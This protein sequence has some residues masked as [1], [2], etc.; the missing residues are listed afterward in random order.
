[1]NIVSQRFLLCFQRLRDEGRVRSAR[2]FAQALDYLPQSWSEVINGRREVTIEIIRRA[3]EVFQFNPTYIFT[4]EGDFFLDSI[5]AGFRLTTVLSAETGQEK[6]VH[7]PLA[8]QAGYPVG[9]A[10]VNYIQN[11]PTFSLPDH[12]Y[13][14]GAHRCF[15][16]AGDAM[17]PILFEGDKVIGS[18]VKPDFWPSSLKS[19]HVY[20]LVTISE[21]LVRRL[22]NHLIDKG[23]LYLISDNPYYKPHIIPG[24]EVLEIWQVRSKI[25]P[26]LNTPPEHMDSL[27]DQVRMLQET[28]KAQSKIVSHLSEK[29]EA[30]GKA[31]I[32]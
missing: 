25:S 1:M 10:D 16:M 6:I 31:G 8:A 7:V 4:G 19:N 30:L 26:F 27:Q 17:E 23:E 24:I 22:E 13:L 2:S 20:V 29:I 32:L 9:L 11:L 5:P 12:R 21:V 18:F 3:A 15:D 14:L 28:I